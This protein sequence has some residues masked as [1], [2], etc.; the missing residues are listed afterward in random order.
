LDDL[1][2]SFWQAVDWLDLCGRHGITLNPEKFVF[3]I[4]QD[5]VRP[6]KKYLEAICNFPKPTNITDIQSW[7]GLVNRVSYVFASASA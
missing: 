3:E 6:A 2:G 1:E 7:F 4:T 5:N